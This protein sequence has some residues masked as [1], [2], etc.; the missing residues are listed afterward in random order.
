MT[1]VSRYL[2][3]LEGW[4][5]PLLMHG[6]ILATLLQKVACVCPKNTV[7]F[8]R[9]FFK[10]RKKSNKSLKSSQTLRQRW[11]CQHCLFKPPDNIIE[12]VPINFKR[13]MSIK[14]TVTLGWHY[15]DMRPSADQW[16]NIFS[17]P[18]SHSQGQSHL[19]SWPRH[20]RPTQKWRET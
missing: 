1:H 19:Y 17:H 14:E 7:Y 15:S 8:A 2:I 11:H 5:V 9:W 12:T 16:C 20:C 6:A 10:K 4:D 3:I 18:L 13:A